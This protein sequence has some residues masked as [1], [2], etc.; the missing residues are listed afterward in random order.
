[1][2]ATPGEIEVVFDVVENGRVV[3]RF[4]R[5]TSIEAFRATINLL[6]ESVSTKK[7]DLF[8]ARR[9][10]GAV[11]V[12]LRSRY[13]H[14]TWQSFIASLAINAKTARNAIRLVDELCDEH[15]R[16]VMAKIE[17]A[18]VARPHISGKIDT[19]HKAEALAG[20]RNPIASARERNSG[21]MVPQSTVQNPN[22]RGTVVP[23]LNQKPNIVST[24]APISHDAWD[25]DEPDLGSP[26]D[27]LD[28]ATEDDDE[29]A[30]PESEIPGGDIDD[31]EDDLDAEPVAVAASGVGD[32]PWG[33]G[34]QM[35]FE[36]LRQQA[37]TQMAAAMD[38]I[39]TLD[40]SKRD[41]LER[42]LRDLA[43]LL[44]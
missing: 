35:S 37:R 4:A 31:D 34:A 1:M 40:D 6:A 14:G 2:V 22:D 16:L 43:A 20:I 7:A 19:L 39:N 27:V 41:A 5:G 11:L 25:A 32:R 44:D 30:V 10:L 8:A 36:D 21:T 26:D 17:A 29:W 15:G 18:K 38:R 23:F 42:V 28:A 33:V 24:R 12:Q 3:Q 13:P 9:A